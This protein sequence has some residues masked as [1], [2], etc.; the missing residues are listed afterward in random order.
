MFRSD[1]PDSG[2]LP[3]VGQCLLA[4][5]VYSVITTAVYHFTDGGGDAPPPHGL[6]ARATVQ[7]ITINMQAPDG[8]CMLPSVPALYRTR[9]ISLHDRGLDGFYRDDDLQG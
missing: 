1:R 6:V 3:I 2:A 7:P 4:R 8:V 9:A 5:H